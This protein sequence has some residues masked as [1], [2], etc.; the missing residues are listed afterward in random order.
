MSLFYYVFLYVHFYVPALVFLY[1]IIKNTKSKYR[2][3]LVLYVLPM[4]LS[5]IFVDKFEANDSIHLHY[6]LVTGVHFLPI[7]YFIVLNRKKRK[8]NL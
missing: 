6:L 4:W 8:T 1:L 5:T 7:I 2:Y 3:A